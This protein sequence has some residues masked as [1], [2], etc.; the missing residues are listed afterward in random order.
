MPLDFPLTDVI[1]DDAAYAWFVSV[2]WPNG[3]VCPH[4]GA[5]GK[6]VGVHNR[7]QAPLLGYRC[8]P[9][10]RTFNV[11]HGTIF[12]GSRR[13]I[14]HRFIILRGFAQGV[15]TNQLSRELRCKYPELLDLRHKFQDSV[16]WQNIARSAV[17][18]GSVHEV[19]EMYQNAGEKRRAALRAGRSAATAREQKARPW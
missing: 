13:P 14:A 12:K 15:S 2:L 3:P 9:C 17:L 1:T 11:F 5:R 10:R 6:D 16:Y 4:C 18:P 19:G 7:E 8:R